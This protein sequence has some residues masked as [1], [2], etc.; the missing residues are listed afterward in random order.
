MGVRKISDDEFNIIFDKKIRRLRLQDILICKDFGLDGVYI[1][2]A[3][4]GLQPYLMAARNKPERI[5]KLRRMG[6]RLF[7]QIIKMLSEVIANK[8]NIQE[9]EEYLK[10]ACQ[11]TQNYDK[12][13]KFEFSSYEN[14]FAVDIT[15]ERKITKPSLDRLKEELDDGKEIKFTIEYIW[16][17]GIYKYCREFRGRWYIF[18]EVIFYYIML[19]KGTCI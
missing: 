6:Q 11:V 19:Q 18:G 9:K 7:L 10:L 8:K 13:F 17:L 15:S 12:L 14:N 3:S 4:R 1:Y 5:K 16:E 2:N